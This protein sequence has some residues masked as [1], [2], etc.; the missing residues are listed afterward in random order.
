MSCSSL[1]WERQVSSSAK[2]T[3]ASVSN[4]L[5][6]VTCFLVHLQKVGL[7]ISCIWKKKLLYIWHCEIKTAIASCSSALEEGEKRENM[8]PVH[9]IAPQQKKVNCWVEDRHNHECI[10]HKIHIIKKNNKTKIFTVIIVY[11]FLFLNT[12]DKTP[13]KI[14]S[15]HFL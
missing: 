2:C 13:K 10:Q 9:Q 8:P 3:S 14:L 1:L 11:C 15:Q 4:M 6:A 5:C 7:F 12:K